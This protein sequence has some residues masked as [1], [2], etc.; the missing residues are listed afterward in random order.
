MGTEYKIDVNVLQTQIDELS[1]IIGDFLKEKPFKAHSDADAGATHEQTN[2]AYASI[3]Q[4]QK[5]LCKLIEYTRDF[6][7]KYLNVVTGNDATAK[8]TSSGQLIFSGCRVSPNMAGYS[9]RQGDYNEFTY[10]YGYNAGCCAVSYAVGL[11]IVTGHSYDPTSFWYGGTTHYDAGHRTGWCEYDAKQLS[12][13]LQAGIPFQ[14]AYIYDSS[15]AGQTDADHFVLI[16][17]IREGANL[18]NLSF[19]DFLAIDPAY[20]DER[21]LSQCW[22]FN[23]NRVTGGFYFKA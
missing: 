23:A 12:S 3:Q 9:L 7:Q 8:V 13:N 20:G 22:K 18:N 21:P 15:P 11:S 4:A 6:F 10:P 14:M 19:D 16:T 1:A 17:G 2:I 5:Q